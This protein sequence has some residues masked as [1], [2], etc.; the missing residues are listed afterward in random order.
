MNTK[1]V[2]GVVDESERVERGKMKMVEEE[3]EEEEKLYL[4]ASG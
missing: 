1:K 2:A 3:E 4:L